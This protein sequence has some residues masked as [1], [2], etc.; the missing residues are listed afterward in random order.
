MQNR[1]GPVRGKFSTEHIGIDTIPS[2][3]PDVVDF[4]PDH[5]ERGLEKRTPSGRLIQRR[6]AILLSLYIY[7]ITINPVHS[8]YFVVH[9]TSYPVIS[10]P[11]HYRRRS[12]VITRKDSVLALRRSFVRDQKTA[13]VHKAK[14]PEVGETWYRDGDRGILQGVVTIISIDEGRGLVNGWNGMERP[15]EDTQHGTR[16]QL[17]L[18]EMSSTRD[19]YPWKKSLPF[20]RMVGRVYADDVT[21]KPFKVIKW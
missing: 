4:D 6:Y 2:S 1:G 16:T 19:K 7:F 21:G 5:N 3:H 13:N 15:D 8:S 10:V 14:G 20:S 12:L 9:L 11:R 18:H 17:S